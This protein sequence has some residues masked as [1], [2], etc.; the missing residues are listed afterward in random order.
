MKTLFKLAA[1]AAALTAV[2]AC[3]EQ[4][5]A[6]GLTADDSAKLNSYAADLDQNGVVNVESDSLSANA[7]DEWTAAEEG[8]PGP[9][10]GASPDVNGQ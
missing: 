9:E 1:C 8:Q 3:G 5:G 6:D 4:R 10:N 2:A 7:A